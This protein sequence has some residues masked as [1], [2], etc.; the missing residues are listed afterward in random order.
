MKNILTKLSFLL[1]VAMS[2]CNKNTDKQTATAAS[3]AADTTALAGEGPHEVFAQ[4]ETTP[5]TAV[6]GQDAADDP[7]IWFNRNNED[8]SRVLGTNKK[9][10]LDLYNLQGKRVAFYPVGRV[11]NVDVRYD[12]PWHDT[13][14]DIAAATNRS[15]NRIDIWIIN[16][17][18]GDLQLISDTGQGANM[19][20]VYGFS[21]YKN[22]RDTTFYAFAS[23]KNGLVVQWALEAKGDQ[24]KLREVRR[25]QLRGQVEGMVADDEED[26]IYIAEEL[27]GIFKFSALPQERKQGTF[28]K[29]SDTANPHLAYDLEGLTLFTLPKGE[30]YLIASSQGNNRFLVFERS[31]ENT[32]RGSFTVGDSLIDGVSETDGIA[33]SHLP[34]SRDF[35]VGLFVCQ[36]GYNRT[37]SVAVPQNFKFVSWL[38]ISQAFE[39]KLRVNNTYRSF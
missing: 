14:V 1:L 37:D 20:E 8:S 25:L 22:R 29:Y 16:P 32:Y 11:N 33:V 6:Q 19:G 35:P 28:V 23:N 12:F 4:A 2:S 24:I 36:D 31:G 26:I 9:Q 17:N 21:L 7:A 10:G 18:N 34:L 30:G 27:G 39:E 15:H 13:L 38:F 3:P 5:V